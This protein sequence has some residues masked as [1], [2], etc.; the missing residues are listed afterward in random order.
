MAAMNRRDYLAH[1][2]L[3]LAEI[4]RNGEANAEEV[5]A[6]AI[7]EA[8]SNKALNAIV[9]EMYDEARKTARRDLPEGPLR[10]VPYLLKDLGACYEGSITTG[11][12][13]YFADS[14]A[15]HDSEIVR[16]Y[17]KAGLVV[18]GKSG[19]P[20]FGLTTSTES[21]LFGKTR[22]PWNLEYSAGGSS[23]G[24]AAAVAAGILPAAHASDGGG[25]IRIPASCCGLF[26]LKPTRARTPMGPDAGEGWSGL[27]TVH[28]V[29]RSVRDSAALLDASA[30]PDAGDPYWAPPAERPFLEEVGTP[31]GR[32]RIAFTSR[33]FNG[34]RTDPE[35][36]HAVDDAAA[37]CAELGHEVDAA[38]LDIDSEALGRATRTIVGANVLA[39]LIERQKIVGR[40]FGPDD[41]EPM[42]LAMTESARH[43]DASAYAL[44]IRTVHR[45]GRQVA[46]FF[47]DWDVLLTPTMAT[48]PK[49]LGILAL[50]ATDT[51]AYLENL[52]E[53]IGFT[54]LMN[55]AG[56]PAVSIPLAE[57]SA[58]L[59]IGL[60]FAAPFGDEATLFRLGAQL[61]EA[62][63][64]AD[65]RPR[66]VGD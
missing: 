62:R 5:L 46:A 29:S 1:D 11:G 42:T 22:N 14:V 61:E 16:R 33:T 59:P 20:E 45:V 12:C 40:E 38:E 49:M 2:A 50:D 28:A 44:A 43:L 17:R 39:N 55:V 66:M 35:C 26:G 53:T 8:E 21:I 41:V 48:P 13:R 58:G 27:S 57:S 52:L 54:Q 63:P 3:G 7:R 56:N 19:S 9:I 64:W 10:G 60:Q 32:L 34:S 37:I 23:G 4:V 31:P 65:R 24:S 15:D 36:R 30:G 18:F 51:D 6:A 25:S 47:A